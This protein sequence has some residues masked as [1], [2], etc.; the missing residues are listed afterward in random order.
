MFYVDR[1]DP[2]EMLSVIEAIDK[3]AS[4]KG[5]SFLFDVLH[6]NLRFYQPYVYKAIKSICNA[7]DDPNNKA[8]IY[9]QAGKTLFVIDE[10]DKSLEYFKT[11]YELNANPRYKEYIDQIININKEYLYVSKLFDNGYIDN[12][13]YWNYAKLYYQLHSNMNSDTIKYK[14]AICDS[15][16]TDF[17]GQ[18]I[19]VDSQNYEI[20][21]RLNMIE[22]TINK[23]DVI[24]IGVIPDSS[25]NATFN[26]LNLSV[27]VRNES[28]HSVQITPLLFK[29][30]S[31][32][33]KVY[34]PRIQYSHEDL[35]DKESRFRILQM[36][37]GGTDELVLTFILPVSF[38]EMEHELQILGLNPWQPQIAP[39]KVVLPSIRV[40]NPGF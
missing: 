26:K 21:P 37:S 10:W 4:P 36:A 3:M 24:F 16:I 20:L 11:A 30:T 14:T 31:K 38:D 7:E 17:I 2:A 22:Y 25:A 18:V 35:A 40:R 1:K 28:N 5:L 13:S 19:A 6:N 27:G 23:T 29:L 33:G 8:N 32:D 9:F 12:K 39:L 34:Y 15:L